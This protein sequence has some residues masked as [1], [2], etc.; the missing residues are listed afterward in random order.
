MIDN[1]SISFTLDGLQYQITIPSDDNIPYNLA[2]AFEEVINKS[3]A[4]PEI[5]IDELTAV[6][7]YPKTEAETPI[8]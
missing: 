7:G 1:L 6:F 8:D 5:V 3:N 2:A 4:N